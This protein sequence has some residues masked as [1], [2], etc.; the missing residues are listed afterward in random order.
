[1]NIIEAIE[2]PNIFRPFLADK[3]GSIASWRPWTTSL[4]MLYGLPVP[5][6]DLPL[7]LEVTGRTQCRKGGF[8]TGLFLTGRRSGK[9][10]IAAVVG[11]FESVLAGH[12]KKLAKGERGVIIIASPTRSQSRIVKDYMR[13]VFDVPLLQR[14]VVAETK[15]GFELANGNRIE[16]LA[17]DWKTIRGFTV[18]AACIDEV[19]F[20][21]LDAESKVK[22]DTELIRAI[23]PSLATVGGRLIAISSPYAPRG[24][25]YQQ[26][27]RNFGNNDGD[28]LVLNAPSRTMN[29]TLPQKVVDQAM[30]EDPAAAR[31]EYLGM[32]RDDVAQFLP[33]EVIEQLVV[34][35]RKELPPRNMVNYAAFCDLSGG[36]N[37]DAALAIGHKEG[38]K[39]VLDLIRQWKPPFSPDQA[40]GAMCLV[41]ARYG[42]DRCVGDNYSAEW[43]KQ[44]FE[45]RGVRYERATATVYNHNAAQKVA[46]PK[47][48]LYAELLPR[49]CSG[50][51]ELLDNETL[52]HQLS[53]LERRTRS[54]GRDIID[55]APG[56]HDDVANVCAGVVDSVLHQQIVLRPMFGDGI[57]E[58]E[59]RYEAE[60]RRRVADYEA[61]QRRMNAPD[62]DPTGFIAARNEGRLNFLTPDSPFHHLG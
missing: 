38:D 33:R 52:V 2:D 48:Q 17:G 60:W 22:S 4:R 5:K 13:A 53:S 30:A 51:I 7:V 54:G 16:I 24:W 32:F 47:S 59:N 41:L 40:V 1:M 6:D 28:T 62:P 49:L 23:R 15:E 18:I 43:V 57:E 36:R 14:E 35:N 27:Q 26:Y 44:A 61:E 34:K 11:A 20:F 8:D 31:A 46:K 21:G 9:S 56:Q 25:S 3:D 10:R 58:G 42:I 55:H 12:E 37:D 39:V 45:S 50:E 29:T 19:C